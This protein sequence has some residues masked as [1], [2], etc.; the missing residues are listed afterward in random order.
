MRYEV[1]FTANGYLRLTGN[2]ARRLFPNDSLVALVRGP[3]MW[4]MPTH[5]TASGGLL[6]KQRNIHGDRAVLV[7]EA[8]GERDVFGLRLA[9]WDQA[10][11]ALRV[12]LEGAASAQMQAESTHA[13]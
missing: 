6:L 13:C 11:G 9:F 8:L 7:A 4:L 2:V 3:E 5:G 1:E 10:Q 12:A